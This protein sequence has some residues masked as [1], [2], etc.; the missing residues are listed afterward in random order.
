MVGTVPRICQ[1]CQRG[2]ELRLRCTPRSRL[3]L[4][5][6]VE[7]LEL[8]LRRV[9]GGRRLLETSAELL[10]LAYGHLQGGGCLLRAGRVALFSDGLRCCCQGGGL[11]LGNSQ[12]LHLGL[13]LLQLLLQGCPRGRQL[14]E[15][16]LQLAAGGLRVCMGMPKLPVAPLLLG[17]GLSI[18]IA[19]DLCLA[20][21]PLCHALG[22]L[23]G[24][25]SSLQRRM[26]RPLL[27]QGCLQA[28]S[29]F[30]L[31]LRL[32]WSAFYLPE[33]LLPRR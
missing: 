25:V 27:G 5:A 8:R 7:L 26:A 33:A 4:E 16:P 3:L 1:L 21:L 18:G 15:L 32:C 20:K 19:R 6:P 11:S 2:L 24:L 14:A 23:S 13:G 29:A 28:G 30:L 22:G 12:G 10:P 17:E 9:P 31:F